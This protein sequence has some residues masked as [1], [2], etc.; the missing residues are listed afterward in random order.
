MQYSADPGGLY[1]YTYAS[2]DG[3]WEQKDGAL[4]RNIV[5]EPSLSQY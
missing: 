3:R 1:T 5:E 4:L 2:P